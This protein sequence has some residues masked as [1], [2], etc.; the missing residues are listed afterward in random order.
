M[1]LLGKR[2]EDIEEADLQALVASQIPESR[3]VDYK[4]DRIGN[5]DKE[6]NEFLADVTSF[7][8]TN[9]G[10]LLLGIGESNGLPQLIN[11]IDASNADQEILRLEQII[12]TGTRPVLSG[13]HIRSISLSNGRCVILIRIP[14][15]WASPHQVGLA[16]SFRF[17][18]RSSNGKYQLDVDALRAA[19]R[20]GPELSERVRVFRLDRLGKIISA[21][22]PGNVQHASKIIVHLV[23]LE[24]FSTRAPIDL[25]PISRDRSLLISP[26]SS[27]GSVRV[28]LD[29]YVALSQKSDVSDRAYAQLFRDGVIEV[30]IGVDEWEV[31]GHNFLP[32]QAFD[33]IV[34][35]A[36]G[37]ASKIY[38]SIN[39]DSPTSA[40]LSL[41]GMKGRLMGSG[42]QWGYESERPF[43]SNEILC[44]DVLIN[45]FREAPAA[46]AFPI[47]NL[48]WNA[49]GYE[50]SA[51]Y[52]QK[53]EWI[54]R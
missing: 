30:V 10:E 24:T 45:S 29:G 33:E 52:N 41:L 21:D 12:R 14:K 39:L 28:N 5:S 25:G 31:R 40:M 11:G 9:G 46:L 3:L 22:A 51:F 13:V 23:P 49:A 44:P 1:S 4:Q 20:Q 6:R 54:G 19:F 50:Q 47:V 7:A 17:F 2:I 15:S 43:G 37:G 27:G 38:S 26:L 48:A 35:T 42:K 32:G 53:G 36:L 18:G 8:N 34:Q 16:G